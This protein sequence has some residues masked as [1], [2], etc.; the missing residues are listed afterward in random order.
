MPRFLVDTNVLAEP[1]RPRPDGRVLARLER[2]ASE[3]AIAAPTWCELI[4]GAERLSRSKRREIVDAF[5]ARLASSSVEVIPYDAEAAAWHA[6]ERAR[7]EATGK[8]RPLVDGQ[9]AA[10]A[11]VDDLTL[12]TRNIRDFAPFRGVRVVDWAAAR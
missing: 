2:H 8:P 11:A 6:R 3:W 7:L 1:L 5:V 4:F 9:I 10:I 12:V